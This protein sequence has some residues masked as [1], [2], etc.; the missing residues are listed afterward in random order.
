M[1]LTQPVDKRNIILLV[2]SMA[3]WGLSFLVVKVALGEV[4]PLT[5]GLLRILFGA[6]PITAF[7]L[8]R[9][10]FTHIFMVFKSDPK[11]FIGIALA[12]FYLPMAAQNVGMDMMAPETAASLSSI[13]QATSPIFGIVFAAMF[14]GEYIDVK[15]AT[16]L[17]MALTGS[18]L[19]VTRGGAVIGGSNMIGNLLLL[20]SAIF[21]AVSGVWTKKALSKHEPIVIL[22]LALIISSFL[23][24]P[25]ALF[26]EPIS[27]VY[28]I[29]MTTW[30]LIL[31]LGIVCNGVALLVWY[32]I[33]IKS[34]LSKQVLFTYLI[35]LFGTIFSHL[36][37]GELIGIQTVVFGGL[38]LA[39]ITVAQYGK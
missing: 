31:F 2:V 3:L 32:I 8:W 11:P 6:V 34:Q 27:Q 5:L 4:Q 15:K 35:P 29:S 26:T 7:V 10:G 12:Q 20:S 36:F 24:I 37:I 17:A 38:I 16:G 21:Y 1:E 39:G 13:L 19:L 14:L 28:N 9:K 30:G 23:F 18:I 33:L 22:A 25:T